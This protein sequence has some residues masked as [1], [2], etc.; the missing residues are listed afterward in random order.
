MSKKWFGIVL[1]A[2][3]IGIA[4]FNLYND[5]KEVTDI[6]EKGMAVNNDRT[7]IAVGDQAP[8]FTLQTIDGKEINLSDYKGKK[9]FLNLCRLLL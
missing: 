3:L 7:G 8:D 4:G 6:G 2:L 9:V 1:I 5:R